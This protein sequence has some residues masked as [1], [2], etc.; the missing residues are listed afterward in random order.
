MD[1]LSRPLQIGG[2]THLWVGKGLPYS[3][4]T[5]NNPFGKLKPYISFPGEGGVLKGWAN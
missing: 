2:F 1:T 5:K 4:G 3:F